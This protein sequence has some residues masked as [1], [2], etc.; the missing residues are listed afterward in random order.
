MCLPI[1]SPA[2]VP[3]SIHWNGWFGVAVYMYKYL[4][5]YIYMCVYV[6]NIQQRNQIESTRT[7]SIIGQSNVTCLPSCDVQTQILFIKKH[8][9]THTLLLQKQSHLVIYQLRCGLF[10]CTHTESYTFKYAGWT[11]CMPILPGQGVCRFQVTAGLVTN[12]A[13]NTTKPGWTRHSTKRYHLMNLRYPHAGIHLKI[14]I[15]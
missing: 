7:T 14:Y 5:I 3:A 9:H 1:C 10:V 12:A 2:W 8:T 15:M 4:S 13:A 6:L 11:R